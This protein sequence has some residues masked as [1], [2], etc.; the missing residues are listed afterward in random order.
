M[1]RIKARSVDYADEVHLLIYDAD[2]DGQVNYNPNIARFPV[3]PLPQQVLEVAHSVPRL[4]RSRLR[5][6]A[7]IKLVYSLA[8]EGELP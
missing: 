6:I 2:I 5:F 4:G 3:S 7:A 1:L 8:M